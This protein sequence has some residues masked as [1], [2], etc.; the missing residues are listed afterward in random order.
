SQWQ[1]DAVAICSGL[2]VLPNIPH[3]DGLGNVPT[4]MHSSQFKHS[5]QFGEGKDVLI[6]GSGETGMDLAYLAVKSDTN[7][8]TLSHRDGFHCGLKRAPDPI[9]FGQKPSLREKPNVPYDVGASSLFDTA[10]V[11][12]VLRDSALAWGYWDKFAKWTAWVATGT[13]LGYDQWIGGVSPERYHASKLFFNKSTNAIPYISAPYRPAQPSLINKIRANII[14]VPSVDTKSRTIDLAPWPQGIDSSG[15][16]RFIKNGRP[17]AEHMKQVVCK[18]DVVI[19][20]TGYT[21]DFLFLDASY[22]RLSDAN[23]R[24]VWKESDPSVAFIGFVRPSFGAIPPLSELQAQLWILNLLGRLPTRLS[25]ED[26]YRLQV[27]KSS[28]I[29]YG[30]DHESYAYQLAKDMGSAPTFSDMAARGWKVAACWALSANVNPKFRMVGPW[31]WDGAEQVMMTE[32]WE[33]I[34]RRRGPWGH[35]TMSILPVLYFGTL[36]A[37]FFVFFNI[38]D[39]L[40]LIWKLLTLDADV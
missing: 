36:S 4:V 21:Q 6:L 39:G 3:I 22:P 23:V 29:Q 26:H 35:F 37:V 19:L 9:V 5:K 33:T 31:K 8:V 14:D 28:R 15:I 25:H 13:Q 17:E 27:P 34:T 18:P 7:S 30:V 12:P 32:I 20:A 11:H 2:H 10:Y 38:L 16:I 1:C 40:M 24:Q